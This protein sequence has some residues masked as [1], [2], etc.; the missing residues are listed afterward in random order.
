MLAMLMATRIVEAKY[1][2]ARVPKLLKP[3]V[4]SCLESLGFRVVD[5]QLV[6]IEA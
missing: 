2:Y 3:Q 5:G 6:A 1:D 4:D